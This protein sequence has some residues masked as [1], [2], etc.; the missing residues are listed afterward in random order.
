M[1]LDGIGVA[2]MTLKT[3]SELNKGHSKIETHG[4]HMN[5]NKCSI[6]KNKVILV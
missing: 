3:L 1:W 5:K 6:Q 4:Q 2:V